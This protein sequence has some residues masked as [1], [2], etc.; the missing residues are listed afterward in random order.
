MFIKKLWPGIVQWDLEIF[1]L[2]LKARVSKT[3]NKKTP[4]GNPWFQL[5]D[6]FSHDGLNA[7]SVAYKTGY[8]HKNPAAINRKITFKNPNSYW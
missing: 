7:T 1:S 2:A 5:R 8:Q 3:C 4:K 6:L